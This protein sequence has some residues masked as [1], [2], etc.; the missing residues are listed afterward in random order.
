M[1]HEF[2]IVNA[3]GLRSVD[4]EGTEYPINEIDDTIA[5]KLYGRTHII[6]KVPAATVQVATVVS[7]TQE[8]EAPATK[9]RSGRS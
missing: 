3:E 4:F 7:P 9:P 1:L 5:A 8:A 6:E 2:K